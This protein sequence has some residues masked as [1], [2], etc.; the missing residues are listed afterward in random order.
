EKPRLSEATGGCA[1]SANRKVSAGLIRVSTP[2]S[3]VP[4]SMDLSGSSCPSRPTRPTASGITMAALLRCPGVAGML[5]ARSRPKGLGPGMVAAGGDDFGR[6]RLRVPKHKLREIRA[7][8]IGE[9]LHE[10]LDRRRLTIVAAEIQIH[11]LA[12]MLRAEQHLEHAHDLGAFLVNR[13]CVEIID[14]A[15]D[16]RPHRMR[17]R[18]CVL[19][20]LVGAQA[21]HVSDTFN[22]A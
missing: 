10:L 16:R 6:A 17:K 13:R 12:E 11:S 14:L 9:T 15:I 22:R 1:T 8:D 4:P 19:D 5:W 21:A 3:M 18:T 2:R 7:C 20:E